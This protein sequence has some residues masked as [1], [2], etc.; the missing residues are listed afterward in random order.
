MQRLLRAH[1]LA[2]ALVV[3]VAGCG[4]TDFNAKSATSVPTTT[5]LARPTVA[6]TAELPYVD[7]MVASAAASDGK[8][9]VS[10]ATYRCIATAIVRG[11]GTGVFKSSGITPNGLRNPNSSLDGLP[12]PTDAQISAIGAA[13]QRCRTGAMLAKSFASGLKVTDPAAVACFTR[14]VDSDPGLRRFIVMNYLERKIDLETA[15]DL[16]GLMSACIDLATYILQSAKLPVDAATR[17][18]LVNALQGSEADLKDYFALR[19]SGADPD[20][21]QQRFEAVTIAMNQCR[22]S[23]RTGFTVPSG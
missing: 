22:P 2:L 21:E 6:T 13:L 8:S 12:D 7:A 5:A 19:I 11:F 10:A 17:A 1:T 16:V 18:C 15:H 4:A 9:A 20:T 3:V 14:R 23:A